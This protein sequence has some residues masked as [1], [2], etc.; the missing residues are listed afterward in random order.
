MRSE[1]ATRESDEANMRKRIESLLQT[2]ART[3]SRRHELIRQ[4]S[5]RWEEAR[6]T[7]TQNSRPGLF[8]RAIRVLEQALPLTIHE[9][10]TPE[11][12][13]ELDD[14]VEG[15]WRAHVLYETYTTQL[16]EIDT[17]LRAIDNRKNEHWIARLWRTNLKPLLRKIDFANIL[18][19]DVLANLKTDPESARQAFVWLREHVEQQIGSIHLELRARALNEWRQE[20]AQRPIRALNQYTSTVNDLSARIMTDLA[21][22]TNDL[23][24][25]RNMYQSTSEAWTR[26]LGALVDAL[27]DE[28]D[29]IREA[30]P[31]GVLDQTDPKF[32]SKFVAKFMSTRSSGLPP[33]VPTATSACTG[34]FALTR[35]QALMGDTSTPSI[36]NMRGELMYHE[37]GTGKTCSIA[38]KITR[39]FHHYAAQEEVTHSI[40]LPCVLLLVHNVTSLTSYAKE[41][42][43]CRGNIV[44]Q[45]TRRVDQRTVEYML[46]EGSRKVLRVVVHRFTVNLDKTSVK[47]IFPSACRHMGIPDAD[48]AWL[49]HRGV[50]IIDEAHILINT[51]GVKVGEDTSATIMFTKQI[52]ARTDLPVILATGTPVADETRFDDLCRLLDL[53]R[54]TDRFAQHD[55]EYGDLEDRFFTSRGPMAS[56]WKEGMREV[57]LKAVAPYVSYMTLEFDPS[58]FPR[59]V[60][61]FPG[62]LDE[63]RE[64]TILTVKVNVMVNSSGKH[65]FRFVYQKMRQFDPAQVRLLVETDE[66]QWKLMGKSPKNVGLSFRH[67]GRSKE[68]PVKWEILRWAIET[69]RHPDPLTTEKRPCKHLIMHP[70][71]GEG[72]VPEHNSFRGKS[73][74]K[75]RFIPWFCEKTGMVELDYKDDRISGKAKGDVDTLCRDWYSRNVPFPRLAYLNDS[76]GRSNATDDCPVR[77]SAVILAIYNDK[78]NIWGDYI[79]VLLINYANKEGIS[80]THTPYTHIMEP[81]PNP[82]AFTQTQMRTI[83]NC[84][85]RYWTNVQLQWTSTTLVYVA[86]PPRSMTD[87]PNMAQLREMRNAVR[88]ANETP[89][90]LALEAMKDAAFDCAL[91]RAYTR[92]RQC[93]TGAG[94]PSR[95]GNHVDS[96]YC[97]DLSGVNR[98]VV[99]SL[100]RNLHG[101][102]I[103]DTKVC[104]DRG[105]FPIRS[106][107]YTEDDALLRAL[108]MRAGF[109][110]KTLEPGNMMLA[111]QPVIMDYRTALPG[112]LVQWAQSDASRAIGS[113]LLYSIDTKRF[114]APEATV[115]AV[116]QRVAHRL[117]ITDLVTKRNALAEETEQTITRQLRATADRVMEN[118]HELEQAITKASTPYQV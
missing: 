31:S 83:R 102:M 52:R 56:M 66:E 38:V 18:R 67:L 118:V 34:P 92:R 4:L 17:T 111:R 108:L 74:D 71:T 90:G 53:V 79:K 99:V 85:D 64:H 110:P 93:F 69:L 112:A 75:T 78:R 100:R 21:T 9:P 19:P 88:S 48:N 76:I 58:R 65:G 98:P 45:E 91:H 86:A 68:V 106:L 23:T 84:A 47:T 30:A 36:L 70:A 46:S 81:M 105:L 12:Q 114:S 94:G 63:P 54:R 14:R 32:L 117:R 5:Q 55:D 60:A 59:R 24:T 39:L 80:V 13:K 87:E 51:R 115:Q 20:A 25:L 16:K 57:F 37:P 43:L 61:Q 104:L 89:V 95:S 41:K 73:T 3:I 8:Q 40:L 42:G 77:D 10:M 1:C 35:Y 28:C 29:A 49:P 101:D 96:T 107:E 62:I 7:I 50:V 33:D 72:A 27:N 109:Q 116:E 2:W 82:F 15:L 113:A 44:W 97:V 6:E 11:V 103:P 26:N 22:M